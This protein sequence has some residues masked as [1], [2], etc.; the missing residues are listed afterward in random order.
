MWV[1]K[2]NIQN[3]YIGKTT[4][5]QQIINIIETYKTISSQ[6]ETMNII[7]RIS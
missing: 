3:Y 1:L 7:K 5:Q 2:N 6:N 4:I